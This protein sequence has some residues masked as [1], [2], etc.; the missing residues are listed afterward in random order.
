M[1]SK[2]MCDC[3]FLPHY[4]YLRHLCGEATFC[5]GKVCKLAVSLGACV[6][7]QVC[8]PHHPDLAQGVP[9]TM[10]TWPGYPLPFRLGQGTP[11]PT[12]QTWLGYPPPPP[13]EVWT[14][15]QTENSTFPHPSDAGGKN[16]A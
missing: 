14:E 8:A 2:S 12:I 7:M 4:F 16:K 1:Y 10:Q 9:P 11:S 6:F 5:C 15:K 3:D 13:V